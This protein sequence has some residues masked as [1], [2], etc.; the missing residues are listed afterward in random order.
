MS[1]GPF[2]K[3]R[4][5][6][7]GDRVAIVAP[8][9]PFP[10]EAFEAGVCELQRLGF[11]PVFEPGVFDRRGYVSGEPVARARALLAAVEDPGIAAVLAARGGYGS[12]ELLPFLPVEAIRR[13]PKLVVGY[14][15]VTALLAFVTTR[16]GVAA[17][18]G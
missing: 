3:P 5:V 11:E 9:S 2:L 10:V 16:C 8:A 6:R 1:D 14:S 15:D 17:L 7:P 18:P 4:A 12:V 13:H